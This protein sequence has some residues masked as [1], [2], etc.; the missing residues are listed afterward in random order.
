MVPENICELVVVRH[1]QTESNRT[2]T[3]Q[4]QLNTALDEL[5]VLQAQAVAGR[6]KKRRFDMVFSSDLARAV[7]TA[8]TILQYH[9]QLQINTTPALREWN[10]GDLQGRLLKDLAEKEPEIM[11]AFRTETPEF[12]IPGG[13]SLQEFQSRINDFLKSLAKAHTGKRLLLVSHGGAIQRML[14]YTTGSINVPN[15]RPFCSNASIAVFRCKN[16]E[17]WQLVTWNDT[18]HLEDLEQ[19]DLLPL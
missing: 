9:P 11:Q 13:E 14:R 4:G 1:G 3:L 8:K 15:V 18:A 19:N 5:G 10:L 2:G 12:K 16:Q 6:L 7:N 17:N